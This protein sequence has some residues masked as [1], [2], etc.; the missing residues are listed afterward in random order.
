M[1]AALDGDADD[2]RVK[3]SV[4]DEGPGVP[5][6][7]RGRIFGRFAQADSSSTRAKGGSGLGLHITKDIVERMG[8]T[9]GYESAEGAGATFWMSFPAAE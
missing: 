8:G 4:R 5:A 3:I 9:I 1:T 7:F 6:N 2:T